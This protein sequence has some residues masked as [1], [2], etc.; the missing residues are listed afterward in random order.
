MNFHEFY[1][2][3]WEDDVLEIIVSTKYLDEHDS[4][5]RHYTLDLFR[6]YEMAGDLKPSYFKKMIEITFTNLFAFNPGTENIKEISDKFRNE[7]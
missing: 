2:Y 5:I 3:L 1:D 7:Y 4:F 6:L